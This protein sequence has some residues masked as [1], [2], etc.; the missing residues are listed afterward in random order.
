M[1]KGKVM[2]KLNCNSSK[3]VILITENYRQ[4]P[5][6]PTIYRQLTTDTIYRQ[7]TRNFEDH[8]QNTDPH[9]VCR[10]IL[11]VVISG[12]WSNR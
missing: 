12:Y 7:Q 11:L 3:G 1:E 10:Y 4:K 2:Q 8:Q 9:S 6:A 5:T